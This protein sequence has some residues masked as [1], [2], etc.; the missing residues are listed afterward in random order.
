MA[1][2]LL[3]EGLVAEVYGISPPEL[4][5]QSRGT[6]VISDARQMMMYLAHVA[7]GLSCAEVGDYYGRDRST[8]AYACRK[9]ED[10][11]DDPHVDALL[12]RIEQLIAGGLTVYGLARWEQFK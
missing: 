12:L 7:L 11:R 8:V 2:L 6:A 3:I 4:L 5:S 9:W 10:R 1:R